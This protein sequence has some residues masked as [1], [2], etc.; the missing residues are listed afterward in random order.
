Y[1][2]KLVDLR[3]KKSHE[4]YF[5]N[6]TISQRKYTN[7]TEISNDDSPNNL[8]TSLEDFMDINNGEDLQK[9]SYRFLVKKHQ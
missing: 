5:I 1:K 3:T 4:S 8:I 7:I 2:G 9:E 6:R